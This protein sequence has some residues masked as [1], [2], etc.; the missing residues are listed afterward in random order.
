MIVLKWMLLL[1][2]KISKDIS[3]GVNVW[4]I[5]VLSEHRYKSKYLTCK[6]WGTLHFK[7]RQQQQKCSCFKICPSSESISP[8]KVILKEDYSNLNIFRM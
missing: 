4:H 6:S 1:V 3:I 7:C 5:K 8:I 2:I